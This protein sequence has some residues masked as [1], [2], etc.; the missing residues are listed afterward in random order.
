MYV[1]FKMP[2]QLSVLQIQSDTE[3]EGVART[4]RTIAAETIGSWIVR[5]GMVVTTTGE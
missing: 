4:A 2:Q 1:A 3:T 5:A